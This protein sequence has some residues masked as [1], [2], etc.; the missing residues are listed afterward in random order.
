MAQRYAL[1]VFAL[2]LL[3]ATC[4]GSDS[5]GAAPIAGAGGSKPAAGGEGGP[6]AGSGAG[7]GTSGSGGRL[8]RG[9]ECRPDAG[10][11]E[12]GGG[13]WDWDGCKQRY[14]TE[15]CYLVESG[16]AD[17]ACL[18][19]D[20]PGLI[21]RLGDINFSAV[22]VPE[23]IVAAAPSRSL[24]SSCEPHIACCDG[25]SGVELE[26][27]FDR[28]DRLDNDVIAT[29]VCERPVTACSSRDADA[30][31]SDNETSDAGAEPKH[32]LCCYNACGHTKDS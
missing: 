13:Y 12:C 23:F 16:G 29:A 6:A 8:S 21:A 19:A 14:I 18:P 11:P 1:E 22:F 2:Y 15:T 24:P 26:T 10:T 9:D 25:L 27:C 30:G 4:C 17:P 31:S 7:A 28:F 32:S 5:T 20:D 3:A